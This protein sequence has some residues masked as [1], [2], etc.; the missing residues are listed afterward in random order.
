[1]RDPK[2]ATTGSTPGRGRLP[3]GLRRG[4]LRARYDRPIKNGRWYL[5]DRQTLTKVGW[6]DLS[7]VDL[8]AIAAALS[9]EAIFLALPENPPGGQHLPFHEPD[10][11]IS[12][13][14][15]CWYDRPDDPP[16]PTVTELAGAARYAVL[17]G[18]VRYVDRYRQANRLGNV[19]V[20]RGYRYTRAGRILSTGKVRLRAIAPD[21]LTNRLA[22]LTGDVERRSTNASCWPSPPIRRRRGRKTPLA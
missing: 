3:G 16:G 19:W 22:D 15:W 6:G 5:A 13:G 9:G 11:P 17:D 7:F 1:M 12:S 14:S 18:Q 8:A 2:E 4:A 21:H 10:E 20:Q